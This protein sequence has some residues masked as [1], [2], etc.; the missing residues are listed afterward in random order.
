MAVYGGLLNNEKTLFKH[1]KELKVDILKVGHHGSNT[2]SSLEFF[3]VCRTKSCHHFSGDE[4][5]LWS[6]AF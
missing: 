3:A 2:S 6:S 5:L 1:T 4:Q